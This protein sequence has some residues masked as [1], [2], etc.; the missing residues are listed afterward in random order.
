MPKTKPF[1]AT[2]PPEAIEVAEG[3]PIVVEGPQWSGSSIESTWYVHDRHLTHGR[4]YG[5]RY[6]NGYS[7]RVVECSRRG[8]YDIEVFD[9]DGKRCYPAVRYVMGVMSWN[10]EGVQFRAIDADWVS[11]LLDAIG[12]LPPAA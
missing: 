6:V 2:I 1:T 8:R 12:S 11:D 5:G 3:H 4:A 7:V 9:R 10:R